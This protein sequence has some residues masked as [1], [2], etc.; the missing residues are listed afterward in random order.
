MERGWERMSILKLNASPAGGAM[1]MIT[2][3]AHFK[4]YGP[5][6]V[7]NGRVEVQNLVKGRTP[8]LPHSR[9]TL[10]CPINTAIRFPNALRQMRKFNAL[11]APLPPKTFWKKILAAAA[12][13]S[14]ISSLV[15]AAK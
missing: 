3:R 1:I 11:D 12:L 4:K 14:R 10:D 15:A 8:C 6:G 13:D 9:S 2:V 7:P 5:K